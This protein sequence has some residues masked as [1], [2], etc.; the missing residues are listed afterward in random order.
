MTG[1]ASIAG[2]AA[3]V[4]IAT[5]LPEDV[6]RRLAVLLFVVARL[7]MA[8]P[9]RRPVSFRTMSEHEEIWLPLVDEPIGSIVAQI[10]ADDPRS[11]VWS[12]RRRRITPSAPSPPHPS[13]RELGELLVDNDV[14]PYDSDSW[15]ELLYALR[16]TARRSREVRAVADEIAADPRYGEDEQLGPD[17]AARDRFHDFARTLDS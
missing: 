8:C 1:I 11:S 17:Q 4:Q 6:L 13:R 3:S 9:S 16:R 12:A 7:A 10:G 14:P 15:I 2:A 5:A